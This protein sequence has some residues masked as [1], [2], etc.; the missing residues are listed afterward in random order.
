MSHQRELSAT[1][2]KVPFVTVADEAYPLLAHLMRPYFIQD[3]FSNIVCQ[4]GE[5]VLNVLSGL[6]G[7]NNVCYPKV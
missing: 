6:C 2:L 7:V 1:G 3:V 5:E 4:E